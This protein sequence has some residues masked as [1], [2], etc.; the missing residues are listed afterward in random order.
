MSAVFIY[1]L[2]YLVLLFARVL[3]T[4]ASYSYS[5]AVVSLGRYFQA[6]SMLLRNSRYDY[7][8]GL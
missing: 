6:V 7:S 1:Y 4:S 3:D 2:V 5:K 8:Q